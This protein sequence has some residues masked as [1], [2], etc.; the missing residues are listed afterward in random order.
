MSGARAFFRP[1]VAPAAFRRVRSRY[2]ES[3]SGFADL[4]PW[5]GFC[6]GGPGDDAL[7]GIG[8]GIGVVLHAQPV[9]LRQLALRAGV[10]LAVPLIFAQS[11]ARQQG[12]I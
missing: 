10:E 6:S 5:V 12:P 8:L 11:L 9:P 4:D 1:P 3:R 7:D 2:S